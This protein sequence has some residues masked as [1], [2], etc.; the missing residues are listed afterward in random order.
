MARE[1]YEPSLLRGWHVVE[2]GRRQAWPFIGLA[3]PQTGRELRL[4]IDST[5]SVLPG[6]TDLRQHDDA[7]VPALDALTAL[8]VEAVR[9]TPDEISLDLAGFTLAVAAVPNELT[10]H[11]PW[12]IAPGSPDA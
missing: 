12:W 1:E 10:S 3:D 7:V 4:Y 9:E 6:W 11:S 5:F 2:V 8:T